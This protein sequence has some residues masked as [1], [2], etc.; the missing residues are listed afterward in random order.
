MHL[1]P[2]PPAPATTASPKASESDSLAAR[3][4]SSFLRMRGGEAAAVG[5]VDQD[6]AD[7]RQKDNCAF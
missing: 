1:L 5:A 4:L 7:S 3:L 6:L 2:S